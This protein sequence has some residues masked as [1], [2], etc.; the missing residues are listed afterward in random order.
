MAAEGAHPFL[1]RC[2]HRRRGADTQAGAGN[3][4]PKAFSDAG[5]A[6]PHA[7]R[8]RLDAQSAQPGARAKVTHGTP[9]RV[10]HLVTLVSYAWTATLFPPAGHWP[11]PRPA[12]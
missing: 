7:A 12:R 2:H 9:K 3:G 10:T 4:Q 1:H 6:G 11:L 5:A 8:R